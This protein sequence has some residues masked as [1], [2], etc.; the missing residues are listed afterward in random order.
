MSD[1]SPVTP[2]LDARMLAD[3]REWRARLAPTSLDGNRWSARLTIDELDML[4]RRCDELEALKR[5]E[6]A[7]P[8][9]VDP[10]PVFATREERDAGRYAKCAECGSGLV[11]DAHSTSGYRHVVRPIRLHAGTPI[12]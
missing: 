12:A 8:D 10:E 7:M 2:E 3:L 1:G 4:L 11:P 6:C 5:R 9:D